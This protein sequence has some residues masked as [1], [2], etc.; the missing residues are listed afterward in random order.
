MYSFYPS[1]EQLKTV[2]HAENNSF[3]LDAL[4]TNTT[5]SS[6]G[7]NAFCTAKSH[8]TV[9]N[10]FLNQL[11]N[12]TLHTN[13]SPVPSQHSS[14]SSA[15]MAAAGIDTAATKSKSNTPIPVAN[16]KT[17]GTSSSSLF[18]NFADFDAFSSK[19]N[20]STMDSK[21]KTN[22]TKVDNFFDAFNDNFETTSNKSLDSNSNQMKTTAKSISSLDKFDA[23][24]NICDKSAAAF[25]A[26][27][28]NLKNS[29]QPVFAAN[30]DAFNDNNFED[31]FFKSSS[32]T[33]TTT[34]KETNLNNNKMK[35]NT[36]PLPF[37]DNDFAKFDA[38]AAL[39]EDNF[40][41]N[42]VKATNLNNFMTIPKHS[43]TKTDN[44][45]KVQNRLTVNA[46]AEKI[47]ASNTENGAKLPEKFV[48]DYSK[49]ETFE[50]DLQ[51]AIKR[52]MV[53]Q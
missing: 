37:N 25:D 51:E 16:T 31:D 21:K 44:L 5:S 19:S 48:S 4:K 24:G 32:H 35:L 39:N 1:D 3:T 22:A 9:S 7:S 18:D 43:L 11:D 34:L 50:D 49:P 53:D 36:S 12:F 38:F 8:S 47:S 29:T 52:S 6:S 33:S 46:N 42:T 41:N 20:S 27:G 23:F 30:F 13:P 28:D 10:E 45:V 15:F 2:L 40:K 17:S 26:F 14:S